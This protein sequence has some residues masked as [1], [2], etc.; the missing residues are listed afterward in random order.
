MLAK[1]CSRGRSAN[2]LVRYLTG[3]PKD[4]HWAL[5]DTDT[6]RLNAPSATRPDVEKPIWHAAL[7]LPEHERYDAEKWR[8]IVSDFMRHIGLENHEW[9]AVVHNE[10]AHQHVHIVANRVD[11]SGNVWLGEFDGKRAIKAAKELEV[12]HN[13]VQ[14]EFTPQKGRATL[15]RNEIER[16]IRTETQPP[17]LTIQEIIDG[18]I[19]D[20]PLASTFLQRVESHGVGVLANISPTTGRVSGMAFSY[21]G[22]AF[23]GSQLGKAYSWGNLQKR[24]DYEQT[25]DRDAIQERSGH[26]A[27]SDAASAIA[28]G[29]DGGGDD[30]D[31]RSDDRH[32]NRDA[33]QLPESREGG[34]SRSASGAGI[35]EADRRS[36]ANSGAGGRATAL[37]RSKLALQDKPVSRIAGDR[38]PIRDSR[39][40][41]SALA[42]AL[43]ARVKPNSAEMPVTTALSRQFERGLDR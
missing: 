26:R 33:R 7:S 40:R 15:T 43:L 41:L 32:H 8:E 35:C 24:I 27:G 5:A 14:E 3:A 4:G 6:A 16:A 10:T 34:G 23:K 31:G 25:R 12:A 30:C 19:H 29:Q 11:Y 22:V 42:S 36:S 17:R 38:G 20:R 37:G 39:V 21:N 2:R 9:T 28:R 18:A 13:L 1:V